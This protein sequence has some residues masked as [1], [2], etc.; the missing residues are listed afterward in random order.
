MSAP[1]GCKFL[2]SARPGDLLIWGLE[3]GPTVVIKKSRDTVQPRSRAFLRKSFLGQAT[4]WGCNQWNSGDR[5][6]FRI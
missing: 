5:I 6:Y 1:F 2:R 4:G 3:K